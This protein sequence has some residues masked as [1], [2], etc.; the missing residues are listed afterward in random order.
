MPPDPPSSLVCSV[1]LALATT[2]PLQ[3]ECLEPPV[4][5]IR[6]FQQYYSID[7]HFSIWDL[8]VATAEH[9]KELQSNYNHALSCLHLLILLAGFHQE[10]H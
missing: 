1:P 7:M 4:L 6:P 8:Q 3:S 5:S 10:R 9:L 2:G